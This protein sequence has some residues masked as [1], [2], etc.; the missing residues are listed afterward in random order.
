MPDSIAD[1]A[2]RLA[3][4]ADAVCRHYLAN[5]RRQGRYWLVGDVHNTPGRSLFVRLSGP[6]SGRGSAGKWT[7]LATGQHGDLLDLIALACH[8]DGVGPALDEARRFLAL[9][10]P[11]P[12]P[13][14]VPALAGSPEAARRLFGMAQPIAGTLAAVYL[15]SR[16]LTLTGDLG[17]LRYHPH[18]WRRPEPADAAPD[19]T[20]PLRDAWPAL[21]AAVT[22]AA[23]VLT[24]VQRTWLDPSGQ[25]KAPVATPRRA[26]GL[27]L[28][29]AVRFPGRAADGDVLAAGEGIETVLSLRATLP[30]LPLAACLSAGHL[31]GLT[32]PPGLRRLYVVRDNDA[33]GRHADAV[34][35]ARATAAGVAVH[36]LAPVLGDCNDDLRQRGAAALAVTLRGQLA[37]EDLARFWRSP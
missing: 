35:T 13:R 3:E 20:T 34:L 16:G 11:A 32:L 6:T 22:D 31:A 37:P 14:P 27:L 17:A 19:D 9:P 8:L 23:G 1:I 18:C 15:A 33:A 21:I 7:D 5:G 4:R 36:T 26:L 28:G 10:A 29:H 30:G 12:L 24:G 25:G 2:R